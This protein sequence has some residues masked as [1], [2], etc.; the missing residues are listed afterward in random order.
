[1]TVRESARSRQALDGDAAWALEQIV[2]E[3]ES[4]I[5]ELES[6]VL[7]DEIV[8]MLDDGVRLFFGDVDNDNDP[9]EMIEEVEL[10]RNH[11]SASMYHWWRN[12]NEKKGS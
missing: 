12:R 2:Q 10:H 1:M 4:R 3:L 7:P 6:L 9:W 8:K 5:K 11:L